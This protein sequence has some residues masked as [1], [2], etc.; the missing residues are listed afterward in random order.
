[1]GRDRVPQR[2]HKFRKDRRERQ[3]PEDTRERDQKP[4]KRDAEK[5]NRETRKEPRQ[6]DP[7]ERQ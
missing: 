1:M 4:G 6:R 3:T 2:L 5:A 7:G